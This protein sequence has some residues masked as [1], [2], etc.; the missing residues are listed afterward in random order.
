MMRIF[1]LFLLLMFSQVL[2]AQKNVKGSIKDAETKEALMSVSILKKGTFSGV[3]SDFEGNFSMNAEPGDTLVFSY[4]GYESEE[5]AI[6]AIDDVLV[7]DIELRFASVIGETVIVTEGKYA[8]KLEEST[9]SVDVISPKMLEN[10]NITSLDEAVQKT[11]GVQILDGQVS[12]RGGAGYAY[13]AGSRVAFLVDGQPLLS[14]E[15]S[16]VKWNFMPIENAEQI[17][18]IKGAASVLYGSGALNG[19]VN[20]RTAYPSDKPYTS[21][22]LYSG[23]YSQPS[24]DSMRWFNASNN[25]AGIPMQIGAFFAHRERLTPNFDLV[26]G[27]NLHLRNGFIKD[28]DERRFRFNFNTRYRQPKTDGRVSYGLN[29]N[30]MYH[31]QGTFFLSEDLGPKAFY[32]IGGAGRDRY[33]SYTLDPY[34]TA[35]DK[36]ENKHDLR[37]RLFSISKQRNGSNNNSNGIIGNLEYQ[38]HRK[39]K[40]DWIVTAGGLGQYFHVNSILFNE[41]SSGQERALFKGLSYAAYAQIDK[42]IAKRLSLTFGTR[43]EAFNIASDL[44]VTPPVIRFGANYKVTTRDYLRMSFGQGFR[45]PSFAE[46]FINED[47]PISGLSIKIL[48]N[49][50]L[51]PETGWSSELAYRHNFRFKK[52]KFYS[53]LALFWMEYENMIEFTLGNYGGQLGFKSLNMSQARIAGWELS[54]G[55]SGYIG[56]YPVRIWGGYTYNFPGDLAQ[57]TTLKNMGT[58]INRMLSTFANGVNRATFAHQNLLKYRSLHNFRLDAETE[59]NK[60]IFGASVNFNSFIQNIDYIFEWNIVVPYMLEFREAHGKGNWIFDF[61]TG[62]KFN[63]KQRLNLVVQNAFNVIYAPRPGQ[64]GA[65]RLI[66]LKYQHK[67]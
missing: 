50:N 27:G 20:V 51:Q 65:P 56:K 15:L 24:V 52:F 29:G 6:G 5:V 35:F 11:S 49:P 3:S 43:M 46:R 58:Y 63:S 36:F 45:F 47:L 61:R 39:F 40:N 30:I 53:D 55:A 14:A 16:D 1:G 48:P 22:S 32:N 13:G 2:F 41:A 7:L 17:E 23:I 60:W 21:F 64:M 54:G 9:A 62:Y 37:G 19:V 59:I 33:V 38:F 67:F 26:I 8:K 66:T 25:F 28:I 34:I 31:E 57:D 12:I 42:K 44:I 18:I 4:I 10:N